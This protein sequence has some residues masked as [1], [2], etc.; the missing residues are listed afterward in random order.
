VLSDS[1][2]ISSVVDQWLLSHGTLARKLD[3]DE[4]EVA[5]PQDELRKA[6]KHVLSLLGLAVSFTKG[7]VKT[8]VAEVLGGLNVVLRFR[9]NW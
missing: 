8:M 9:A 7:R 3:K 6:V 5:V 4:L 1:V 2:P